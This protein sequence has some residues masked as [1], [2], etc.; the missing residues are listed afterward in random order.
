[1]PETKVEDSAVAGKTFVITGTL[2]NM[3][4]QEA[5]EKIRAAG[6]KVSGSVS[7][8]TDYVVVGDDPGTKATRAQQLGVTCIDLEQF[9]SLLA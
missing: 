1:M 8:R 3:T 7:K 2:R 5:E 9:V 4:R 6:G